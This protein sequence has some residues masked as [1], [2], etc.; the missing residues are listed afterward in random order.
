[1]EVSCLKYFVMVLLGVLAAS[2]APARFIAKKERESHST[3]LCSVVRFSRCLATA[4]LKFDHTFRFE[5]TCFERRADS[6]PLAHELNPD[7]IHGWQTSVVVP[8]R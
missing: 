7:D 1:M 4:H 2:A 8:R 3:S 6:P 5:W